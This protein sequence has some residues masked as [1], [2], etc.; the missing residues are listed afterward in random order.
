MNVLIWFWQILLIAVLV[1]Y[2]AITLY[3]AVRGAFDIRGMLREL[4]SR[5]HDDE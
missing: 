1:W 5:Q 2:A 3:V 4:G